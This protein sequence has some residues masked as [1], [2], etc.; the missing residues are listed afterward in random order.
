MFSKRVDNWLLLVEVIEKMYGEC[1]VLTL[2]NLNLFALPH[3]R[4][5]SISSWERGGTPPRALLHA[6]A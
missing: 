2:C 3:C 5:I 6:A 4:K 1:F